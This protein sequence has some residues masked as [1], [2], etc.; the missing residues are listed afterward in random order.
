MRKKIIKKGIPKED[1]TGRG[2]GA[3]R[4]RGECKPIKR[5]GL[6]KVRKFG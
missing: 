4:G 1:G 2:V 5:R 3:N 6:K